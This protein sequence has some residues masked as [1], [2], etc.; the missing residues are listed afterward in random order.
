MKKTYIIGFG[1]SGIA[2]LS[3]RLA[4]QNIQVI[5]ANDVKREDKFRNQFENESIPIHNFREEDFREPIFYEN[6][7]S[8]FM[9]KPKN[10]F[11]KI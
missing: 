11:K 2:C 8:K 6:E 3:T 9:S 1:L 7:P 5:V 4:N 10:N